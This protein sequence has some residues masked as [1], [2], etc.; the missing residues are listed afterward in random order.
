MQLLV[1]LLEGP[2]DDPFEKN[3]RQ[4]PA[5]SSV[6]L[7]EA[8]VAALAANGTPLAHETIERLVTDNVRGGVSDVARNAALRAILAHPSARSEDLL[9][10]IVTTAD[11]P[12]GDDVFEGNRP[13]AAS[14]WP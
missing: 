8:L 4:R 2:A 12:L 6:E 13:R 3:P 14:P 1:G 9:F 10:R 5:A 7:T 11:L